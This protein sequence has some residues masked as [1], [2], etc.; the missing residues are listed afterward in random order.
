MPTN[1]HGWVRRG[2]REGRLEVVSRFPFTVRLAYES[3]EC[4]QALTAGID[5]GFKT[6]G[7]SVV[8][9]QEPKSG[10]IEV[11]SA[12]V[13]V[14][15]DVSSQVATKKQYRSPRRNRN[16]RHRAARF[17]NRKP[18]K[19]Q[20]SINQ[21]VETHEQIIKIAKKIMPIAKVLF[22][23]GN[24]DMAKMNN[25]K[26]SGTEYQEG[27]KKDYYNTKAYVLARDSHMCQAGKRGCCEKLQVHHVIFKSQGGSNAPDNLITLC[28]KHHD[29]L[30]KKKLKLNVKKHKTLKSATMMNIVRSQV[31]KRNPEFI[32]TYGYETKFE[33]E[34]I[35]LPKS[36]SNDA[37]VIAGG[38]SSNLATR[39]KT[40]I[41]CQKRRNNRSI[42]LNRKGYA[43]SIRRQHYAIQPKD[44]VEWQ[45]KRYLA[46]GIQNKGKYLLIRDE[47]N[48]RLVISVS[49]IKVIFH[50]RSFYEK[51]I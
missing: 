11:F 41:I 16:V 27:P 8:R 50:Q 5:S 29:E 1:R 48:K 51:A 34:L 23:G 13:E 35:K 14:R 31:L 43:P 32:E 2:L 17:N 9:D 25:P 19:L 20:P 49:Q 30:H 36:H 6:I 18:K 7:I 33:R 37:F 22:E 3:S 12:E 15:E 4:T 46:G 38:R 45:G 42:Q 44:I 28:E 24:F 40:F 39:C 26:I 21:K 10:Q 47:K